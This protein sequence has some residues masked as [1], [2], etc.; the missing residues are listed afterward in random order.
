MSSTPP[1]RA[2]FLDRDGVINID[3]GYTDSISRIIFNDEIFE[4]SRFFKQK[5]YKLIIVTNQSGIGRGLITID[6]YNEI[7]SFILER[8]NTENCPVDLILTASVSPDNLTASPEETY[9][10]KPNPGMILNAKSSLDLDLSNS[11]LIGDNLSD[12]HAGESAGVSKLYLIN[13]PP[14]PSEQFESYIN[15]KECLVRLRDVFNF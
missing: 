15:L 13:N 2:L 11:L 9:L 7:T 1:H 4:I 14:I 6:Q 5:D 3:D 10:R 8:F 12:M